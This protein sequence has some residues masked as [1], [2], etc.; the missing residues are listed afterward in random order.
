MDDM[1]VLR[2]LTVCTG[3]ICRSP[4][5]AVVLRAALA[6]ERLGAKVEVGSAGV[7]WE[8]EGA[9]MD[10]RTEKALIG[11][12]Y[13]PPFHHTARA[14]H[15]SALFDWDLVLPMTAAHAQTLRRMAEGSPERQAPQIILWRQFDPTVSVN[16]REEEIPVEDPWFSGHKAFPRM[17]AMLQSSTPAI[18][19][20]IRGMLA[21]RAAA[22][23]T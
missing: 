6:E 2:V 15:Q 5:A 20:H 14:I 10:A 22:A 4:A 18:V 11:A 3:N 13:R 7:S 17:V 16:A 21:Q 9:A 23:Q 8:A 12:G 1:T 19:H